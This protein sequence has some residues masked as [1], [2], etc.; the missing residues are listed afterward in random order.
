VG[1]ATFIFCSRGWVFIL[2]SLTNVDDMKECVAPELKRVHA[3]L[4]NKKMVPVTTS[5]YSYSSSTP[6]GVSEYTLAWAGYCCWGPPPCDLV[7]PAGFIGQSLM[8]WLVL[9]HLKQFALLTLQSSP[10]NF[11]HLLE[12]VF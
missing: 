3:R 8:K 9:P 10:C 12:E 2:Q 7:P 1:V 4:P 11:P 5:A 6:P